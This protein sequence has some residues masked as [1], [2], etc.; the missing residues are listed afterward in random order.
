MKR[1]KNILLVV[2]EDHNQRGI[3]RAV[4]LAKMND[5]QLTLIQPAAPR[6]STILETFKSMESYDRLR[7]DLLSKQENELKQLCGS[8]DIENVK[9]IVTSDES[10]E[11]A[12]IKQVLRDNH[13]LVITTAQGKESSMG[14]LFRSLSLHL[15]RKCPCPV[16][17]V[18]PERPSKVQQVLAAVDPSVL[19]SGQSVNSLILD[20]ATS[21]AHTDHAKLHIVHTYYELVLEGYEDLLVQYG[22]KNIPRELHWKHV[23]EAIADRRDAL[24]DLLKNH[25]IDSVEH[26][27]HLLE[28]GASSLISK[29]ANEREVDVIVLGSVTHS[30]PFGHFIGTTAE[31]II[32]QVGCSVLVV[33]PDDFVSPIQL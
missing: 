18:H 21:L 24:H 19:E 30:K 2:R 29:V 31:D 8:L 7:T 5:A 12:I 27:V 33:K 23:N 17:V 28:G 22:S 16:W 32:H 26:E 11:V 1:Y 25:D 13:D 20:L 6:L 4:D 10:A 9:A 3:E 15:I 14:G